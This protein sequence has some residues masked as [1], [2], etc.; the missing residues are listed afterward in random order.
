MPRRGRGSPS[1]R[2]FI[3][4]D[5]HFG[6]TN[7]LQPSPDVQQRM[8]ERIFERFPDLDLFI[9]SGD[10]HHNYATE[11]DRRNWVKIVANGCGRL[12][13]HFVAGNHEVD[14]WHRDEDPEQQTCAQASVMARPYYSF[15]VRNI[16]FLVLPQLHQMSYVSEESLEWAALD[17]AVNRDKAVIVLSHNS[18]LGTTSFGADQ[19]YRQTW[20][21]EDVF[22]LLDSHPAVLAWMHGHNHNFEVVKKHNRLYVSN[23]RFGG[24][25]PPDTLPER[26]DLGGIYLEVTPQQVRVRAYNLTKDRWFDAVA[27]QAHLHQSLAHATGLDDAALPAVSYGVGRMAPGRR[28]EVARHISRPTQRTLHVTAPASTH[29][30]ALRINENSDLNVYRERFSS[31]EKA[32]L[33]LPGYSMSPSPK[34]VPSDDLSWY[35]NDGMFVVRAR[36]VRSDP[37]QKPPRLQAPGQRRAESTYFRCAPGQ[38]YRVRLDIETAEATRR[39]TLTLEVWDQYGEKRHLEQAE[40]MKLAAGRHAVEHIFTVPESTAARTLYDPLADEG[41][42]DPSQPTLPQLQ[43]NVEAV[44]PGLGEEIRV[45]AFEIDALPGET[46]VADTLTI[47][48]GAE[49][50]SLPV[51]GSAA[52]GVVMGIPGDMYERFT[53]DRS[54]AQPCSWLIREVGSRWQVRNATCDDQGSQLVIGPVRHTRSPANEIVIAPLI[55]PA[56]D[57]PW[58]HRLRNITSCIVTVATA[59]KPS[60]ILKTS[61]VSAGAEIVVAGSAFDIDGPAAQSS[62][63]GSFTTLAVHEDGTITLRLRQRG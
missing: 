5:A 25:V 19:V 59:D 40:T 49:R 31:D 48:A 24:F 33:L 3:V 41:A 29:A 32:T 44:F 21:S 2:A 22:R 18:L 12:P 7:D 42:F 63:D 27:E 23:G 14:V 38:R 62:H 30:G 61:G 60:L 13:F 46:A 56:K 20:N 1:L 53:V 35:W 52:A 50:H 57:L 16:H 4:S 39:L 10:G 47:H 36:S 15:D 11:E 58:L 6:W 37:D 26:G 17:L 54:N 51:S 45:H 28:I 34:D 43:M 8:M 9:D 55:Q